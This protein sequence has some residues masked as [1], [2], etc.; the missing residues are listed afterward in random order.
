M[1]TNLKRLLWFLWYGWL[2]AGVLFLV[3]YYYREYIQSS[4][5]LILLILLLGVPAG[6]SHLYLSFEIVKKLKYKLFL[7]LPLIFFPS[8]FVIVFIIGPLAYLTYFTF[9]LLSSDK[10]TR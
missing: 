1:D 3:I 4:N 2:S 6:I 9:L 10:E 8:L 7:I 5:I